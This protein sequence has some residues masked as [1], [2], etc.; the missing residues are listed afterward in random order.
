L[1]QFHQQQ[2]LLTLQRRK[3]VKQAPVLLLEQKAQKQL[4]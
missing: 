4:E 3:K 1:K 2:K